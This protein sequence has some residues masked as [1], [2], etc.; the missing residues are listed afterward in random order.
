MRTTLEIIIAVKE[1]QPSTEEE[2][3]LA[4]L[5]MN[6]IEHFL[7][8]DLQKLIECIRQYRPMGSLKMQ[9]EFAWG[10]I[11]RMFN[12]EK[13]PPDEW[14]GPG[15]IPGTPQYERRLELGKAIFKQATGI[16]LE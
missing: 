6:S 11:E 12:A 3:R 14:L 5:A 2:L 1:S 16:D 4:L 15:N 9:A 10:T 7:N 8:N 13:M